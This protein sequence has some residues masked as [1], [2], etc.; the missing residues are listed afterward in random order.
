MKLLFR[1]QISVS[2]YTCI[3]V[4]RPKMSVHFF[5]EKGRLDIIQQPENGTEPQ[6]TS[7]LNTSYS[8]WRREEGDIRQKPQL[9]ANL[10]LGKRTYTRC[11]SLRSTNARS[12]T[13]PRDRQ[14]RIK[15]ARRPHSLTP[16]HPTLLTLT[17]RS[18]SRRKIFMILFL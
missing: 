9:Q 12:G 3:P 10:F 15:V 7:Y 16:P 6:T 11:Q 1:T 18:N 17:N 14:D 8:Q 2:S 5:G 13:E 4:Y